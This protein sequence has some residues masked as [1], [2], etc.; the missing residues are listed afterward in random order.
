MRLQTALFCLGM[1][2][3]LIH[4]GLSPAIFRQ[5]LSDETPS[6]RRVAGNLHRD[7]HRGRR[8]G[9]IRSEK[10]GAGGE[11]EWCSPGPADR[12]PCAPAG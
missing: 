8:G 2:D 9:S 7:L 5:V 11:T 12:R 4:W 3:I 1:G 10:G 6:R